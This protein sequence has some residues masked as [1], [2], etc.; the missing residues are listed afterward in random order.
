MIYPLLCQPYLFA[1]NP[2]SGFPPKIPTRGPF[3]GVPLP[4]PSAANG[5][6]KDV[7]LR[8]EGA[9]LLEL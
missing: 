5:I 2:A 9:S 1:A 3:S 7:P 6:L 8:S 4:A